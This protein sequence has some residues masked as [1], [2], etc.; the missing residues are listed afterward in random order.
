MKAGFRIKKRYW[1]TILVLIILGW[2]G[3][4]AAHASHKSNEGTKFVIGVSQANLTEP[5]RVAMNNEIKSESDRYKDLHVI[6]TD[7]AHSIDKQKQDIN[8]LLDFGIDLLIIST[9][10]SKSLT[11]I[12]AKV[13]KKIPVIVLGRA[14]DGYDYSLFIGPANEVIGRNA[15]QLVADLAGDKKVN[16]VEIQG[17]SQSPPVIERSKGFNEIIEN[18][19]NIHQVDT[20]VADWNRDKA[21]DE[22]I[23][24]LKKNRKINFVFAHSDAMALGVHRALEKKGI[25]GVNIIGVD[26]LEGD[27]GGLDLVR[28]NILKGTFAYRTGG[29]ESIQYAMDLLQGKSGIPKK[30]LLRVNKI[31]KENVDQYVQTK[32]NTLDEPKKLKKHIVL[33]F[34]QVGKE[35]S[36]RAANSSSIKK[37]A[38]DFDIDLKFKNANQSIDNQIKAIRNFIKERV[39]VIAFSP[40]VQTGYEEVLREAKRAG[41]PVILTDREL[42]FNDDSL[43][44]T[45]IGSDFQEE[46]RRAARWLLGFTKGVK[47]DINIV[48]LQGTQG[49]S[50]AVYRKKG[51]EELLKN[52]TNY[53]IIASQSADFTKEAGKRVMKEMLE[54][55]GDKIQVVYSHNDDMALG[56]IEAIEE[57]GKRPGKDI[58]IISVDATKEA[59][60]ALFSGKLNLTVECNPLLGPELMKVILDY[61]EGKEIPVKIVT[62]EGIFSQDNA[63][64]EFI[65]RAY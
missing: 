6:Y 18:H 3:Y 33:G 27:D 47:K 19:P 45:S 17:L 53:H 55:Y 12:I 11:P 63:K 34:V 65:N 1:M 24:R 42:D 31:T 20:I 38:Q 21:E 59:F 61:Q 15:G 30:I 58:L 32:Q 40:V 25:Q 7:A 44:L 9:N 23:E 26:G 13:H 57:A 43:W 2:F 16:L 49:S 52:N 62:K 37:A 22:V 41:I 35:S 8:K 60:N 54:R 46:G 5:W 29:N 64:R 39:D 14:I 48:E 4:K 36:W 56:A 50:P 10:D 28:R 51:F